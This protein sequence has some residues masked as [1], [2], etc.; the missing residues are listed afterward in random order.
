MFMNDSSIPKNIPL[1]YY[2]FNKLSEISSLYLENILSG[3][4]VPFSFWN[5]HS[6]VLIETVR[7][8][9]LHIDYSRESISAGE[10]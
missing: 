6:V 10:S 9:S 7:Q 1:A 2:N 3:I 4:T 8:L 5:L